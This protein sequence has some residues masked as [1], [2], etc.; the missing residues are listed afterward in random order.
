[1]SVN[2]MCLFAFIILVSGM[3]SAYAA[4]IISLDKS[5]YT[6]GDTVTISGT[7]S[8]IEDGMFVLLQVRS[9]N[10]IV[11]L[12]QFIPQSE[13]FSKSIPAEGPKWSESGTYTVMVSYLGE[14]TEKT[15]Q[16]FTNT[17]DPEKSA[18]PKDDTKPPKDTT[19]D[20]AKDT[21]KDTAPNDT[22][23]DATTQPKQDAISPAPERKPVI[24]IQG[25]PDPEKS[26]LHYYERYNTEPE[27]KKWFDS[28]F[29]GYSIDEV[30]G[31]QST[32]IPGFPDPEKPPQYYIDRYDSDPEY[33]KWFDSQFP[34]KTIQ[35]IVISPEKFQNIVPAQIKETA[36]MWA[37]GNLQDD[38]FVSAIK[39]L[40]QNDIIQNESIPAANPENNS[41]PDWVKNNARWW[42]DGLITENDFLFGL[43]EL[44]RRGIIELS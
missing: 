8:D 14:K 6:T 16:F 39:Q 44:L 21:T 23:N 25:F 37:S 4:P 38:S 9:Q 3:S 28:V 18:G 26:P 1:M 34:G 13:S 33:K 29:V 43:E 41:V 15:F 32:H 40:I 36:R 30:L 31:Y 7:L 10:D 5:S 22:P 19:D 12:D 2:S 20:S 17:Q 35:D 11:K 24:S 27:Y 42:S